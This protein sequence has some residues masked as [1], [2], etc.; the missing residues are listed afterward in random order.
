MDLI[1]SSGLKNDVCV[2]SCVYHKYYSLLICHILKDLLKLHY[3][4]EKNPD[5]TKVL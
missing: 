2:S 1:N 3:C 5:I 4:G